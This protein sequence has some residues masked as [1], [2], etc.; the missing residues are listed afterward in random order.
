[1]KTIKFKDW[2]RQATIKADSLWAQSLYREL[3]RS[4]TVYLIK[5]PTKIKN[6]NNKI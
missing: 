3:E 1:M 6:E 2:V 5:L 4:M